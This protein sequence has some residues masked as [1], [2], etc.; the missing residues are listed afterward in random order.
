MKLALAISN[1]G[2]MLG[3]GEH[4]FLDLISHLTR[5]WSGLAT[6]PCDGELADK[7]RLR[8]IET[9]PIPLPPVRPWQI[10]NVLK[11]LK[12]YLHLCRN[13]HPV[14]IY[15]NGSRAAIYGGIVG[16]LKKLPVVWH[17]RIADRDPGLDFLLARLSTLI[18]ANSKTTAM[19]F[20]R[21]IQSKIRIVYNGIDLGWFQNNSPRKPDILGN[22]WRNILLVARV[23]KLKRHDLAISAF[24]HVAASR[25]NLHLICIGARDSSEPHWWSYLQDRSLG[26]PFA[27]RIHWMG[28][29][30]DLRPWY[31]AA[32]A[33]L[34]PCE[35]ESFGRVLVEAMAC[36]LPVIAARSGGVPEIVRH[37]EDGLLVTPGQE[38]GFTAALDR[39]L[40]D[41]ALR[42][43]FGRSARKRAELFGLDGHVRNM[44]AVF[45]E[46]TA[47]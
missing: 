26:S 24:E 42:R 47:C 14:L 34:F 46:V 44:L 33:L 10:F 7:L 12:T 5:N 43:R 37:T 28:P 20:N 13:R 19:R 21:N 11:T 27:D 4:S 35:N 9:H 2:V 3:G 29:I 38:K 25:P 36:G 39:I 23:S 15:A 1:H 30:D 8:G 17:C 45:D 18:V 32:D 6:V 22:T 16:K 41:D 31:Y 40:S